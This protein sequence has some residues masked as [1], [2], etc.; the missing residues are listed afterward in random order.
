MRNAKPNIIYILA[1]DMGYGDIS[2]FNEKAAFRTPCLDRMC[3][4][5]TMFT[6]A[7]AT[8]AVCTPSR[9]SILTGRYSWRSKLKKGVNSGYDGPLI[10]GGRLTVA[11]ML[12]REGYAT[13]A[14]GKWHLGMDF[15]LLPEAGG[16]KT[17]VDFS[18]V[19]RNSPNACGFD[20]YYGISASLDM[21]PYAYIENDRFT[22]MPDHESE[23]PVRKTLWRKGPVA[24]DFRH[25]EV[26]PKLTEKVLS[27]IEQWKDRPF[28]LY[29]PM[30]APHTPILPGPEFQGRTGF[31][32]GD[33]VLMCD[34]VVGQ[35]S[36][37]L[38]VMG[39]SE[40]TILIFASDNGCAP[41]ADLE[42]M[43]GF[44][45]NPSYVFRGYKADIYEGGHRIPLIVRWPAKIKPGGKCGS[46]VCLSD[47]FVTVADILGTILPDDAAE[48]SISNL[49]LW[50]DA[51]APGVRRDIVHQSVD[52][53]LSIREGRHKLEL[54]PGSGGWSF[55]APGEETADMPCYQ[56]YDLGQDVG[57]RENLIHSRPEIA[58][59]LKTRLA[60]YIRQGRSTPGPAQQND[61]EAI[62]DTAEWLL[63]TP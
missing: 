1:D 55:P 39:I 44:G 8:S 25:E 51:E 19:I 21:P 46:I 32:Y 56:L 41:Y 23:N 48:D 36:K 42:E 52:G 27:Q 62:W 4:Q 53:S 60:G 28:F 45:H 16:D 35:I 20:Y 5:G 14:I 24:P 10:E 47:L 9:Y 18:G 11:E 2:A 6:D 3:A 40:N 33:F 22:A 12:R 13:A 49:P 50:L 63:T 17:A 59:M 15:P 43:A 57:E 29:F 61:G 34:D 31:A 30:P 7:H 37:K 54:C 58:D 26:L 38:E